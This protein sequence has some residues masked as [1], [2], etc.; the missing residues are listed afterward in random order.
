M[1]TLCGLIQ[2]HSLMLEVTG[3]GTKLITVMWLKEN[4]YSKVHTNR[5][6]YQHNNIASICVEPHFSFWYPNIAICTDFIV[7]LLTNIVDT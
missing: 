6:S 7:Y 1:V 3:V 2:P 5:A 4:Y